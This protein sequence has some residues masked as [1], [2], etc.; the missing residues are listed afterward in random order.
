MMDAYSK[1]PSGWSSSPLE[2]TA[3]FQDHSYARQSSFSSES[4]EISRASASSAQ[5]ELP[6]I[7]IVSKQPPSGEFTESLLPK[8]D[9]AYPVDPLARKYPKP[10]KELDVREALDRKPGR[11]TL[12]HYINQNLVR[13]PEEVHKKDKE[14]IAKDFEAKKQELLRAREEIRRMA[15]PK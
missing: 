12:G 6:S 8:P 13:D 15:L 7:T 5:Q 4:S 3:H 2:D 10:V 14:M 1:L 11:W 9:P